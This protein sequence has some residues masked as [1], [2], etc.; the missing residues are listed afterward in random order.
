MRP[1]RKGTRHFSGYPH[2]F[3]SDLMVELWAEWICIRLNGI[4]RVE[5]YLQKKLL[6]NLA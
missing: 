6:V 2:F 5:Q 1:A 3:F 4:F